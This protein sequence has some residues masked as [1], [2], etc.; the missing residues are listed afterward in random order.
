MGKADQTSRRG[1]IHK[2]LKG[3]KFNIDIDHLCVL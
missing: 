3:Y 2:T 1:R